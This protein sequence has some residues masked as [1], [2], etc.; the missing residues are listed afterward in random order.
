MKVAVFGLGYVG[1]VTAACLAEAAHDVWAVDVDVEK[2]AAV[3]RGVSP[4][5]EP[6]LDELVQRSVDS[7]GLHA[8]TEISPAISEAEVVLICVGTPSSPN[9]STDLSQVD[10]TV[11]AIVR[12]APGRRAAG[13]R[14]SVRRA[15]EH[16]AAGNR[17]RIHRATPTR[18]P[19]QR[20]VRARLCNVP[21][22]PP[23]GVGHLRLLRAAPPGARHRRPPGGERGRRA[24]LLRR[25]PIR[26]VDVRTAEALKYAC[27]AFHATKVSFT[28]ELARLFRALRGGCQ[29]RHGPLLRGHGLN[30]SPRYLRPGFAF[31]GSCLP[32]D[33][34]SLLY[35]AREERSGPSASGRNARIE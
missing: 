22:V 26:V 6:G 25:R 7:G 17:R 2:V 20:S 4:V 16:G 21:G 12:H 32:K 11:D 19:W 28:N 34:R 13:V 5:A 3:S 23:R 18:P 14:L 9:W 35:L 8:T 33:L 31:G 29:D 10:R 1:T 27:N 15:E 24:L 30:L